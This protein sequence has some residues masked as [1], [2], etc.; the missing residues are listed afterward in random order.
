MTAAWFSTFCAALVLVH[1]VVGYL[2][3]RALRQ[4]LEAREKERDE[5]RKAYQELRAKVMMASGIWR[6]D[7]GRVLSIGWEKDGVHFV[8]SGSREVH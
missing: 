6:D 5:Q 3:D 2:N 1:V 7:N 8:D 4:L